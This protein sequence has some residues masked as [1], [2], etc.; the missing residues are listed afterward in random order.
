MD[1]EQ[2]ISEIRRTA[3]KNGNAPLGRLRFFSET[4]IRESDWTKHWARWSDAVRE[5][6]Y[7]PNERNRAYPEADLLRLLVPLI[8]E[9]GQFPVTRD[10]KVW[11]HNEPGFPAETTYRRLGSTREL[12]EK[13]VGYLARQEGTGDVLTI[14]REAASRPS[15]QGSESEKEGTEIGFV[16]LLKSGR[17]Y[18]I[19]RSNAA[20]RRGREIA[21]QL[22]EHS[23][24]VHVIATDDPAGIEFYW[25]RR[26]SE[27]RKNGE[28][29]ALT[30]RD[31]AVFR[32][33][34]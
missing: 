24:S 14:C 7:S 27:K 18:K 17:F 32:R 22:P 1:K 4:G 28:W 30:A 31:V 6:G 15:K 23:A 12:A 8:R 16:Y 19:G 3:A 20:G 11:A 29:F 26:F 9:L 34:K 21:L 2:I 10:L 5:A 25:H 13:M 33:R